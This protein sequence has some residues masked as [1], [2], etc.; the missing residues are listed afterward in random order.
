MVTYWFLH[1]FSWLVP[2]IVTGCSCHKKCRTVRRS[3]PGHQALG[4]C[5]LRLDK[6]KGSAETRKYRRS[7]RIKWDTLVD[8]HVIKTATDSLSPF[9]GEIPKCTS[10]K[11]VERLRKTHWLL[12]CGSDSVWP[13]NGKKVTPW[14]NHEVKDAI[15]PKK[16]ACNMAGL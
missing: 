8:K 13:N 5:N 7:Y 9:F 4:V 2:I 15:Q 6:L 12:E 14:W 3:P 16:V 10:Y 1:S 11:D